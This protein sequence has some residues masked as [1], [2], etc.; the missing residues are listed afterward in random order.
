MRQ[1]VEHSR[2]RSAALAAFC[3]TSVFVV[4]ILI[5]S[6]FGVSEIAWAQG[7]PITFSAVGDVPYS[8]SEKPEFQ[9]HMDDHDRYS[10]SEFLV[11]L[12]DIKSSGSCPESWYSEMRGICGRCRFLR[13]SSPVTTNGTIATTPLRR[14]RIGSPT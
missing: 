3:K 1:R 14:G 10:P 2:P 6:L 12:G 8:D 13:L 4:A 5:G 9:Q 7:Q 11:H